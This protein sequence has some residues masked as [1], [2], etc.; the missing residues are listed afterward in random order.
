MM[1]D[2]TG[3]SSPRHSLLLYEAW[4]SVWSIRIHDLHR[5][6]LN[7]LYFAKHALSGVNVCYLQP[8][9]RLPAAVV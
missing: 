3:P 4:N 7:S 1:P 5:V 9:L 8:N 6:P 2:G